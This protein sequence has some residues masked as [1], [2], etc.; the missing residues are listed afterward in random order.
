MRFFRASGAALLE[1]REHHQIDG[2]DVSVYSVAK[3]IA[4][5][6]RYRNKIGMD[7]ALEALREALGDK[8]CPVADLWK[9][10]RICRVAAVMKPYLEALA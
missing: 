5:C 10:A 6:F 3:T 7:I 9:F 8:R 2:V 1:G 4:D